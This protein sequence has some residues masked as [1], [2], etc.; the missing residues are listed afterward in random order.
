MWF[1]KPHVIHVSGEPLLGE[2]QLPPGI[3]ICGTVEIFVDVRQHAMILLPPIIHMSLCPPKLVAVYLQFSSGQS[4]HPIGHR[5]LVA[6]T[7]THEIK[8]LGKNC[9]VDSSICP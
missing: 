3:H 9:L 6:G 7:L 2:T 5:V 4:L 1:R 8:F